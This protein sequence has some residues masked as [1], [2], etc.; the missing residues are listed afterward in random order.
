MTYSILYDR[1]R[2]IF[3]R[4]ENA[5]KRHF[6]RKRSNFA[7]DFA[8]FLFLFAILIVAVFSVKYTRI[9]DPDTPEATESKTPSSSS[10]TE[11][12]DP[13]FSHETTYPPA[14]LPSGNR[15]PDNS[16]TPSPTPPVD[17]DIALSDITDEKMAELIAERYLSIRSLSRPGQKLWSVQNIVVHYVANPGTS[18][19]QNWNYFE[20]QTDD[21]VSAHFIIGLDGEILQLIPLDEV[22][23]AVGSY[24]G[25]FTSISI[26]CCHPDASG[27]FTD[28]TYK[29]LIKLVSWLC[30][31]FG[32]SRN[33]V[34]R[35]Y[36]Y[37]GKPCPLYF[38]NH[39]E[40]WEAFKNSLI[41]G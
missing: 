2:C 6:P 28:A 5:V 14:T 21:S 41:L 37:A 34:I 27:E 15:P 9:F 39:P 3:V 10:H 7:V 22:A 30:N 29:S 1:I 12:R 17:T 24:Q 11:S 4:K 33:D 31:K 19:A 38:V 23:W 20:T 35:H 36:D 40:E 25:N 32:L 8:K 13:V 26:E 18:A 16:S